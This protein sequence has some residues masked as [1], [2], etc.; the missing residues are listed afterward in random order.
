MKTRLPIDHNG[1]ITVPD[2]PGLG[3]ELDWNEIDKNCVSYK[4]TGTD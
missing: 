1:I 2:L 4:K 3:V